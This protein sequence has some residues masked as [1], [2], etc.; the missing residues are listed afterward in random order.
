MAASEGASPHNAFFC[1]FFAPALLLTTAFV[2]TGRVVADEPEA[3]LK[4]LEL[5]N[6]QTASNPVSSEG[7]VV[8]GGAAW[9]AGARVAPGASLVVS[10]P[11][12]PLGASAFGPAAGVRARAA[13][14]QL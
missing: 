3:D 1:V 2:L 10:P 5:V 13:P 12:T 9:G 6:A 8:E 14:H 11:A 4:E 7:V